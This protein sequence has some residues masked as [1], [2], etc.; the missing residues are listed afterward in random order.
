M[1][2]HAG[3]PLPQP[4]GEHWIKL[5]CNDARAGVAERAGQRAG[6]R[7]EIEHEVAAL[8]LRSANELRCELATAE[9]VLAAAAM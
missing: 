2:L 4:V 9:E 7:T 5:D 8:D 3:K 1:D 6:A